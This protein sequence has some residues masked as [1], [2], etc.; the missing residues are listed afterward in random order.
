MVKQPESLILEPLRIHF[1]PGER[2]SVIVP[3]TNDEG[4]IIKVFTKVWT[5]HIRKPLILDEF[6]TGGNHNSTF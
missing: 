2:L 6:T 3:F 1:L 4:Q 5:I